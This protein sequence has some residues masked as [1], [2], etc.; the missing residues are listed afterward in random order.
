M[1]DKL[2]AGVLKDKCISCHM[3][4]LTT[5]VISVQTAD[6]APPVRFFVHTHHIAIYPQEVKKIMAFVNK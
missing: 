3:P 4:E 2:S 6:K 1:T 5:N